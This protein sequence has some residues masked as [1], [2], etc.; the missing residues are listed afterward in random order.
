[1]DGCMDGRTDRQTDRSIDRTEEV[2]NLSDFD[3]WVISKWTDSTGIKRNC[4]P[5]PMCEN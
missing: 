3:P 1:M 4:F 2:Q 5:L